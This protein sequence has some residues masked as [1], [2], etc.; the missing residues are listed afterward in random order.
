MT[1]GRNSD[2]RF[3][4]ICALLI[5]FIALAAC[6]ER[7]QSS[8]TFDQEPSSR[9]DRP[10]F[11]VIV[12]DDLGYTD[13]GVFGSEIETPNL[14]AL[15]RAG[16]IMNSFYVAPT[17][18][19]TRSMLLSGTDNHLA[20]LGAMAGD[21][22]PNQEGV[23]GYEGYLSPKVVSLAELLRD[24]GYHT[25][26]TGKW[27][28]GMTE[29]ASPAARGFEKSFTLLPGGA[30][31]LDTLPLVGPGKARYREDANIVE[32][33]PEDFYS[34]RYYARKLI[35]YIDSSKDDDQPFFAYL[36]FTAP[37]WPLQAPDE[38]IAKQKGNY[39]LGYDELHARRVAA[40]QETGI[41]ADNIKSH[42]R[43]PGEP[44]WEDLTSDEQR[45]EAKMMEIY[46]AMVDDLDGYVG[47]V[48][49]YLKSIDE[50]D[51]TFIVFMS[52]NGAEG[53]HLDLSIPVMGE[54]AE[55][56]CDNSYENMGRKNT[57]LWYGP[58][59]ARAGVGP[60][61]LFKGFTAEGGIRSPTFI[62][63]PELKG[64]S[65]NGNVQTVMDIMPTILDLAGLE[66]PGTQYE[67]REVLPMAGASMMPMLRG[68][69]ES[70]HAKDHVFGWE[71]FGKT[72]LRQG[73]WKIIQVPTEGLWSRHKPLEEAYPWQLY[74]IADDPGETNDLAAHNP[75]KLNEMV[76]LWG[77]YEADYGVIVP[78]EV[79]G[80]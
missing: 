8:P 14:D 73:D 68:E 15:A 58:N 19:P 70:T 21:A 2:F 69:T 77:Q 38:S 49:D 57:Y 66:H 26:M 17:C 28:L 9:Q 47:E 65:G 61:R 42:S 23:P 64:G 29:E 5:A 34:S 71:L 52:D 7:D 16:V 45:R 48:I 59:W 41:V 54:W 31:H 18:S 37:H 55:A 53:H 75:E 51:N 76:A 56:C 63:Y 46:A 12:A 22:A 72:A 11:L 10:N 80:Y 32:T 3:H 20:G 1:N 40:L 43:L 25:Y 4:H 79:M 78:D 62:H 50:F 13:L 30:G 36:A 60:W 27:H 35:D 33:L 24:G 74:N 44:A 39:D 67:G 6:S